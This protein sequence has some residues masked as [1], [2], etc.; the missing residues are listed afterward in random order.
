MEFPIENQEAFDAAIKERLA[1][2]RKKA[3]EQ[4]S[5]YDDLKAKAAKLDELEEANKTELQKAKEEIA[6]LKKAQEDRAKADEAAEIRSKVAKA[7]GI[8]E[9]LIFGDDEDSMTKNAEAI[10]AYA[11]PPAAPPLGEAGSHIDG[12]V[13]SDNP[14]AS[15][16]PSLFGNH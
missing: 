15:V 3:E 1:R 13:S 11:K 12:S 8:P 4:Y 9:S 10:V 16:L 14:M 2:E 6:S 7:T 5:D